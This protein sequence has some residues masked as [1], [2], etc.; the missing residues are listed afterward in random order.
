MH[1]VEGTHRKDRH[2]DADDARRT[3]VE[4]RSA[5]C[6][7]PPAFLS[8]L[9]KREWKRVAPLL[10]RRGL[11]EERDVAALAC[12]CRAWSELVEAQKVLAAEGRTT[13]TAQGTLKLHPMVTVA[14]K[15]S[16]QIRGFCVE[17]GLSPSARMR[18]S[19]PGDGEEN[20][21]AFV[22]ELDEADAG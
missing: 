9:A 7:R 1:L 6:P 2:G 13:L 19:T 14:N 8:R 17:F 12:Y 16:D 5:P 20:F 22:N 18:V 21:D 15:A 10:H 3:I 4:S 11:L